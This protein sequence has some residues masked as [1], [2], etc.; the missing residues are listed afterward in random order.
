[1]GLLIKNEKLVKAV[2]AELRLNYYNDYLLK[3]GVI[4]K[5]E[6][7]EMYMRILKYAAKRKKDAAEIQD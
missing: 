4:T 5:R 2:S 6:H 7:R 3:K 1:M